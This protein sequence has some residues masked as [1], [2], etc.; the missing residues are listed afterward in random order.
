MVTAI[1]RTAHVYVDDGTQPSESFRFES[2]DSLKSQL[3]TCA[4]KTSNSIFTIVL[5]D[6]N[7]LLLK[8]T[9]PPSGSVDLLFRPYSLRGEHCR[10]AG[11]LRTVAYAQPTYH[12]CRPGC[13]TSRCCPSWNCLAR[14][15]LVSRADIAKE[16][17][18]VHV[19]KL[20]II[21]A[22]IECS[23]DLYSIE[24]IISAK[25]GADLRTV[26]CG[27]ACQERM[28]GKDKESSATTLTRNRRRSK[29]KEK[30]SVSLRSTCGCCLYAL[31]A[32]QRRRRVRWARCVTSDASDTV[33][34][35]LR[36]A[37]L[38]RSPRSA[39]VYPPTLSRRAGAFAAGTGCARVR[40]AAGQ[41]RG[42]GTGM[43]NLGIGP[44][45]WRSAA[46]G[47]AHMQVLYAASG[48]H[49]PAVILLQ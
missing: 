5:R 14:L 19:N 27:V 49:K 44:A 33:Y 9:L 40:A 48:K 1:G 3:E 17:S 32:S 45:R 8:S 25:Q 41:R 47:S 11:A 13:T 37:I 23:Q 36:C 2:Y 21:E 24:P 18:S 34:S 43:H 6:T 39:A 7:K 31:I 10:P 26:T 16:P 20:R 12:T 46:Q 15:V 30:E 22:R 42:L 29:G 38:T 4:G 35:V 28:P